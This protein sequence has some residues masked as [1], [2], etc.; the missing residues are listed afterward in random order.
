MRKPSPSMIVALVAL[1]AALTGTAIALPGK[2][3][4]KS[5]DIASRQVKTRDLAR[6][7]VRTNNTNLVRTGRVASLTQTT[8]NTAE[9]TN[10][11]SVSVKVPD[12]A[13][14]AVHAQAQMRRSGGGAGDRARVHLYAPTIFPG[15]PSIMRTENTSFEFRYSTP[16]T[17][18]ADGADVQ[19][20]SGW[21]VLSNV[22]AGRHN[23]SL[24]YS[25]VSGTG[26]FQNRK[27]NVMV[28][29]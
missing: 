5:D 6:D 29:R 28:I 1:I 10:G 22:P 7:A 19:A 4:V 15:A 2:N 11:P 17:E 27:L 16:G 21:L 12:G 8:S 13:I 24:R 23:I 20:R 26:L 25:T 9:A 18:E 14:V 3:T